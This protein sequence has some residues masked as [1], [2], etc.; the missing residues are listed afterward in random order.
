MIAGDTN[1]KH[2]KRTIEIS[3]LRGIELQIS[4]ALKKKRAPSKKIEHFLR[5]GMAPSGA[6]SSPFGHLLEDFQESNYDFTM[7]NGF[8]APKKEGKTEHG[9]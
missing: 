7:T 9:G 5:R 2:M 3:L 8:V 6:A 4:V 1:K